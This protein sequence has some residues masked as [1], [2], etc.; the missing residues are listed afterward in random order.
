MIKKL[1]YLWDNH[2]RAVTIIMWLLAIPSAMSRTFAQ[3]YLPLLMVFDLIVRT[4]YAHKWH[5]KTIDGKEVQ[6]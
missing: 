5:E 6:E 4:G 2:A 1:F 3:F